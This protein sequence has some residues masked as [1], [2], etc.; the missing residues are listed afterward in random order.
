MPLLVSEIRGKSYV[1]RVSVEVGQVENVE[2]ENK[3]GRKVTLSWQK[4][5]LNGDCVKEYNV[6]YVEMTLQVPVETTSYEFTD[7]DACRTY[8]FVIAAIDTENE[9][10]SK[11]EQVVTILEEAIEE[12]VSLRVLDSSESGKKV[13][14][15]WGLPTV[16][17]YC[18]D[19][20]EVEEVSSIGAG[21]ETYRVNENGIYLK[22][23]DGCSL[24]S[25]S[26]T[27]LSMNGLRG[28]KAV[29]ILIEPVQ[30]LQA[31]QLT[32]TSVNITWK[33][34][35][36]LPSCATHYM[37]YRSLLPDVLINT[38]SPYAEI[39]N[40]KTCKS[41][42]FEVIPSNRYLTKYPATNVTIV[43][44]EHITQVQGFA[45][46]QTWFEWTLP[47]K[48]AACVANFLITRTVDDS[49][50]T[51]ATIEV[52]PS[53]QDPPLYRY[54]RDPADPCAAN[55]KT[56]ITPISVG[57]IVGDQF[58]TVMYPPV[59][60]NV[61]NI[62]VDISVERQL[63]VSWDKPDLNPECVSHYQV[64]FDGRTMN[65][66]DTSLTV[67]DLNACVMYRFVVTAVSQA[68]ISSAGVA[69]NATVKEE[70]ISSVMDLKLVETEGHWLSAEWKPPENGSHCVAKYRVQAWVAL[71]GVDREEYYNVTGNLYVTFGPVYACASYGLQVIPES[72]TGTE[73][74]LN[75]I[76]MIHTAERV[77]MY[78]HID[79]VRMR[80]QLAHSLE[81]YTRLS[82][83]TN[84]LCQL[85]MVRFTCRS[86][87]VPEDEPVIAVTGET[88]ITGI[89]DPTV[90]FS[91][92]VSPLTPYNEYNCTARVQNVAGW[93]EESASVPFTTDEYFPE[94]P[95]RL[96]LSRG[97]RR[98][99]LR[100]NAPLVKN[101]IITWYRVH[102]RSVGEKYSIPTYCPEVPQYNETINLSGNDED[103]NARVANWN[104]E[105]LNHTIVNLQPYTDYVVQV[106]AGTKAGLGPYTEM[107]STSTLPEVSDPVYAFSEYNVTLPKVD[108]PYNS[109]VYL[110]WS[111]PCHLNGRL[112]SF[113]GR[114]I[115]V[116]AGVELTLD[117]EKTID[118]GEELADKYTHVDARL[119]PEYV[120]NVSLVVF[121]EDVDNHSTPLYLEFRA[122]A[123]IPEFKEDV[124]WGSV[125]VMGA[126]NPTHTAKISLSEIIFDSEV[127]NIK[128]VALLLS[129]R[130]CQA[131][132]ERKRA[133]SGAWPDM[134]SWADVYHLE[135]SP[136][137]QT[138]PKL[139]DPIA[140]RRYF[141]RSDEQIMFV[142]GSETCD[143]GREYCNGPLKPGTE[144]ALIV[145]IF[146]DSGFSDSPIQYFQTDS[147][148]QLMLIVLT[149]FGCLLVA[150][151]LG[152]VIF[153]RTQKLLAI[154]QAASRS[155]NEE[156]SDIPLKS[157]SGIYEEL[158]QS[159]R[160]KI[161]KEYQAINYF[162]E[163]LV[164]E[165]V[166]FFV[167]KE[168]D[169]KN[170]YLGILPYDGNRVPLEFDDAIGD[171]DEE[172]NDYIN[173]SFIDGYKY[174]R[175]YIATQGPKKETCFDFWRMILQYEVESI[176]M[177][178]QTVENDRIKCYQYF[179]RYQQSMAFRDITVKCTQEMNLTFYQKRLMMVTRG[180]QSKAV[181]HYHF[182]V[183]PDHGCPAS[184]AELIKFIKIVRTERKNLAIPAVVH[185]SAGVGR[186]GTLI[187]L[188]IILQRIQQEKKINIYDT[189]KQL[190]RQR[191]KM[192]QTSEQY[193]FLYQSCLEYTNRGSRKK[194]KTS[195]D[196]SSTGTR[197]SQ[198]YRANGTAKNGRRFNIKF[199]KYVHG[200]ISN[201]KSYPPDD[202]ES[203]T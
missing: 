176:V 20:Y 147:L 68:G 37:V 145:R 198:Q 91:S 138:T 201:V 172:V 171:E 185:C 53:K 30:E 54:L 83:E 194:P 177:L 39:E 192:V 118:P 120:Y 190:R 71:N 132:P 184:P 57:G 155:P 35:T 191:V 148:I 5:S 64:D 92:E 158:I 131:D 180:N 78:Y 135:C 193:A 113:S 70:P 102:I 14:A 137:Y 141:G 154:T 73:D 87:R 19:L 33:P 122:P 175:E 183:W 94:Q 168:N 49:T 133:L 2:V 77:I 31:E 126:P 29:L 182:L 178:T 203:H 136:Q 156:P 1:K 86:D 51:N 161:T 16:S 15:R 152:L 130:H 50:L 165:T 112:R 61:Q 79:T 100:W 24:S 84:N 144:Y 151:I 17:P 187:A 105:E 163:Q 3:L 81:L 80:N 23:D 123:G 42:T 9:E 103:A 173:A 18:V 99:E 45:Q 41:Y 146:T 125:N 10:K 101:G 107:V 4:P 114:L 142:I 90:T 27:P 7:L 98:I 164:N 65:I 167:A 13:Q 46:Q 115:G 116:R 104:D 82:N 196:E 134:A 52:A 170:R 169:R 95:Q 129:E 66:T 62:R 117:W 159:N 96:Q 111:P 89:P 22:T 47:A 12:V 197:S 181:F 55:I 40:L 97:N 28:R 119:E 202:V 25:I 153:I 108:E 109:S 174:Q 189:V 160:E 121:V 88:S 128:Y 186:T 110:S 140:A 67:T 74:G 124:S 44:E 34:P 36:I 59:V 106:A 149:I 195:T 179:P 188:D 166:T 48:G 60:G 63:T 139:W 21:I 85:T 199:P 43:P 162:S 32:A 69:I 127:G 75:A 56:M 150:F 200:G 143:D 93:S 76:E 58:E 6:T 72:L 157:F 38:T 8:N 11:V 26:V